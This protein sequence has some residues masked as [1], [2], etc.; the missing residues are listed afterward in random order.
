M[1]QSS[2][3][4]VV[5]T[6]LLLTA[7]GGTNSSSAKLKSANSELNLAATEAIDYTIIPAANN[8]QQQVQALV[9]MSLIYL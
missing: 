4:L 7:C 8:F 1:S 5:M 2:F 3:L 9:S 6:S